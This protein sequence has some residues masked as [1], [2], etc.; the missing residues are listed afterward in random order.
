MCPFAIQSL[1]AIVSEE[2]LR[3]QIKQKE[4]REWQILILRTREMMI[5]SI[6]A[7]KRVAATCSPLANLAPVSQ[8]THD[9]ARNTQS[10]AKPPRLPQTPSP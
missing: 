10:R 2:K 5:T 8:T 1:D 3:A 6:L 4:K 9:I 7:L